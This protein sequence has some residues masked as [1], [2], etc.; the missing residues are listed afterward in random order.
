MC[1]RVRTRVGECMEK[2]T[3]RG[4]LLN[5]VNPPHTNTIPHTFY[6]LY[7]SNQYR[8]SHTTH[9]GGRG[10]SPKIQEREALSA[11]LLPTPGVRRG[12]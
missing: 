1:G 11:L 6:Q 9:A 7:Q 4:H 5:M 10:A 12:A 3:K 2:S 8:H